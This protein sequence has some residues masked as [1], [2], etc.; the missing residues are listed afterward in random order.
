MSD[1]RRHPSPRPSARR[2]AAR[3]AALLL[4]LPGL[5][6]AAV[7]AAAAAPCAPREVL[8]QRLAEGYGEAPLALGVIGGVIGGLTGNGA[9]LEVLVSPGGRSF[10]ILMTRPPSAHGGPGAP[11]RV[12]CLVAAGE[13][14][15][16][17]APAP[18]APAPGAKEAPEAQ[19]GRE[20]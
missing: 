13:G 9:L 3:T 20:S 4:L 19:E 2:R 15:R 16:P 7:S 11:G 10:S 8:L 5:G 1:H 17:V 14:W 6:G 12:S 18:V